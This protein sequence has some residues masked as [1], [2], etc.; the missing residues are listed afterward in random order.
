[1]Q[2]LRR[3]RNSK[4]QLHKLALAEIRVVSSFEN[5]YLLID[6]LSIITKLF[7]PTSS[8]YINL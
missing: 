1:M 2:L 8:G 7:S 5:L 4:I 3:L 6:K